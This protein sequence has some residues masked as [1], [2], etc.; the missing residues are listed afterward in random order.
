LTPPLPLLLKTFAPFT[1]LREEF[2]FKIAPY[3]RLVHFAP[4]QVLW[5]QGDEA[6]GMYVIEHG[7]LKAVYKVRLAVVHRSSPMRTALLIVRL[8][9]LPSSPRRSSSSP[10]RW[11]PGRSPAS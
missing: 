5:Q 2:W 9:D 3:F 4:G 1:D 11:S 8:S 10:N 7:I 6:E